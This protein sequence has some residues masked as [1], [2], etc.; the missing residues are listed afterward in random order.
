[1]AFSSS[2]VDWT[3][4]FRTFQLVRELQLTEAQVDYMMAERLSDAETVLDSASRDGYL[5]AFHHLARSHLHAGQLALWDAM[6]MAG[7][8]AFLHT[9]P[10][11]CTYQPDAFSW[12]VIRPRGP[13][14]AGT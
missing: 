5:F 3:G 9:L 7:V 11:L 4:R 10:L 1:M 6:P 14:A 12:E 13:G 8:A 2:Q